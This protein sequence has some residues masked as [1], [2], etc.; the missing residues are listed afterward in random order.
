MRSKR[1]EAFEVG[2]YVIFPIKE[3]IHHEG[4]V[5]I[6]GESRQDGT[7]SKSGGWRSGV[8]DGEQDGFSPGGAGGLWQGV[9]QRWPVV[10][11]RQVEVSG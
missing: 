11:F 5:V 1:I 3:V 7:I 8:A 10:G 4:L 2:R 9:L 6:D